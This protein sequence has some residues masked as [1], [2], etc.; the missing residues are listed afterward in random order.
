MSYKQFWRRVGEIYDKADKV[1]YWFYTKIL[2]G[3]INT[4]FNRS[5][6]EFPITIQPL[7]N[8]SR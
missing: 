5:K 8:L 4:Q 3:S 7:L 6:I 2:L 1:P